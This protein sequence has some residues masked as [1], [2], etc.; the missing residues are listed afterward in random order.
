MV[1]D[2]APEDLSHVITSTSLSVTCAQEALDV[3]WLVECGKLDVLRKPLRAD[4]G[5][6]LGHGSV[7]V[8]I[9]DEAQVPEDVRPEFCSIQQTFSRLPFV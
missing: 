4:Q 2:T 5:V 6:L 8:W 3:L 1:I 9:D 7:L